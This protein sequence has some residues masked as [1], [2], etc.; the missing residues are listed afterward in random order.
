MSTTET[1]SSDYCWQELNPFFS[2]SHLK[3]AIFSPAGRVSTVCWSCWAQVSLVRW[4]NAWMRRPK[5]WW[6]WRSSTTLEEPRKRDGRCT[7][8]TPV[9]SLWS[10][11]LY[12]KVC[13]VFSPKM[14]FLKKICRFNH[15]NLVRVIEEFHHQG[16][17]CLV[18]EILHKDILHTVKSHEWKMQLNKIRLIAKQVH[19]IVNCWN[20]W[21]ITYITCVPCIYFLNV[22]LECII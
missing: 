21:D 14:Y 18:L 11:V 4:P 6:P 20:P 22:L 1:G 19:I 9:A 8:S 2:P 12:S 16:N 5:K 10:N 17:P 13:Y 7:G 3:S 15:P